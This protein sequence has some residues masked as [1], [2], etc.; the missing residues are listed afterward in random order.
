MRINDPRQGS[1][2]DT[3]AFVRFGPD[4]STRDTIGRFPGIEMEQ[5]TITLGTRTMSA[6]S[7]VPLGRQTASVVSGNRVYVARNEAWQIEVLGGGGAP[8]TLIRAD[9]KPAPITEA[10]KAASRKELARTLEGQPMLRMVPEALKNQLKQRIESASYPAT[11]P[12]ILSLL[13]DTDGNLWVEEPK[14]HPDEGRRFAV[15][16]SAGRLLGRV[17]VPPRF[18]PA[19]ITREAVY[20]VWNDPDDVEHIRGYPIRRP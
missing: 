1:H 12:F 16:D 13:T 10:D 9:V 3:I 14:P 8:T 5:M 4:G 15:V 19:A 17:S 18:K 7:P 11:H 20:G 6:P 2:R